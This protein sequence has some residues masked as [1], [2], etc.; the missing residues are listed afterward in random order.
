MIIVLAWLVIGLLCY[1]VILR[2]FLP[3]PLLNRS[4]REVTA[5]KEKSRPFLFRHLPQAAIAL[6]LMAVLSPF[7]LFVLVCYKLGKPGSAGSK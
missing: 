5:D 1:A 7:L 3:T 2:Y 6:T 4:R